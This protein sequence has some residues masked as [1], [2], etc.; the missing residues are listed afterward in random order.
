MT[1]VAV[2]PGSGGADVIAA[3]GWHGP[4]NTKYNGFYQS[5]RRRQ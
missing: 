5:D 2:V 4:G 3:I 1:D